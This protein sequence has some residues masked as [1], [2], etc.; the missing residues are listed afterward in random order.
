MQQQKLRM[1]LSKASYLTGYFHRTYFQ[2]ILQYPLPPNVILYLV[3]QGTS[4]IWYSENGQHFKH[5]MLIFL[6]GF[7]FN[8]NNWPLSAIAFFL[9]RNTDFFVRVLFYWIIIIIIMISIALW[10]S[11]LKHFILNFALIQ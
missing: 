11:L 2:R 4:N 8:N 1:E 6:Q 10:S 5:K 3:L 9:K 7:K